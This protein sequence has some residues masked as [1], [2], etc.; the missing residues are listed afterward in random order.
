MPLDL[1]NGLPAIEMKFGMTDID[2]LCF[3]CHVDSCAAINIGNL[4]VHEY[5]MTEHP[6][7]VRS[8]E[9]FE[10]ENL[11]EPLSLAC[12]VS[13]ENIIAT[14]DKLISIVTYHTQYKDTSGIPLKL[15]FGLGAEVAVNA[16]IGLPTLKKWK[17]TIDV[18][19]D[20]FVS[21]PLDLAFPLHFHGADSGLPS[22]IKFTSKDFVRPRPITMVGRAFVMQTDGV[23]AVITDTSRFEIQ[24]SKG[25]D[26]VSKGY[27]QRRIENRK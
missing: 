18:G 17:A 23:S 21:K 22:S 7:I 2:E 10:H 26:D 27:L 6:E 9:Q 20:E 12:A 13:M 25:T 5:I 8:Y 24:N 4:R 14:Y 19:N 1:D 16:I 11:F 3:L 15:A